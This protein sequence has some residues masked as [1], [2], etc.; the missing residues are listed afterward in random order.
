M[1]LKQPSGHG[2]LGLVDGRRTH[3]LSILR[4][5][6]LAVDGSRSNLHA[7]KLL[8]SA[9]CGDLPVLESVVVE[10]CTTKQDPLLTFCEVYSPLDR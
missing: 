5:S 1:L 4:A 10:D 7:L 6:R 8:R 9:L 2:L 3:F